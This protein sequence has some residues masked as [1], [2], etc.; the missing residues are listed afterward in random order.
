MAESNVKAIRAILL[1][2]LA[3]CIVPTETAHAQFL[4]W[5]HYGPWWSQHAPVRHKHRH[6]HKKPQS[7][8]KEQARDTPNGPLQIVVSIA[9]QRI[10]VYDNGELI[11]RSSVSTGEPRHP[12]P[13]GVFSVI[14]KNRWHRSNLYS[15]APMPYMQRLTWSGIALHAGVLPGYPASHGCIRL[16]R[17]FAV[18]LWQLTRRGTRIIIAPDDIRPLEIAN[19]RLFAAKPKAFSGPPESSAAS[20]DSTMMTA[21]AVQSALTPDADAQQ[22]TDPQAPVS[23]RSAVAPPKVVPIS[24][25]V[26]RKLSRL[27]VRQGS[28]PLFDSPVRIQDP[29]EPLG[30]HVFTAM[31]FRDE[32]AALRWTVVSMPEKSRRTLRASNGRTPGN[33][34]VETSPTSSSPDKANAALDRIEMAQDA[35]ERI[36]ERVTPGSSL[37]VSDYGISKETGKGTDFIVVMQ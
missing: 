36:A 30:T 17:D 21:A 26:S 31:E 27:F 13:L 20:A 16:K 29:E 22:V 12:T 28:T 35:V 7:A 18:R 34:I 5:P 14:G 23:T 32:G 11:A 3:V 9:D 24:V 2:V 6:R 37:I 8:K 10:A 4:F 15:A 19:P 33:Q 25:F 1:A